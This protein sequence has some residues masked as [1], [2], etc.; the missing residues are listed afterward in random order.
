[1]GVHVG[2]TMCCCAVKKLLTPLRHLAN[3]VERLYAEAE[4]F[5]RHGDAA[6]SQITLGILVKPR[7]TASFLRFLAI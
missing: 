4:W 2:A 5:W 7:E 3:T 1:M 6:C